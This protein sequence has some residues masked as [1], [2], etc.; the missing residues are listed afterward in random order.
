M[1]IF[2]ANSVD[3]PDLPKPL[4]GEITALTITAPD[5]E[6]SLAFYQKLGFK[7]L[8]RAD[9]PFPW[10]QITDGALL[11]MLRQDAQ[12]Y[13]ALTYYVEDMDKIVAELEAK[14]INFIQRPKDS[15]M[16]KRYLFQSPDALNISLVTKV[17]GFVQPT[18]H[19]LLTMPQ[20]DLF[21]PDKYVNKACGIF[22]EFTHT[23]TDLDASL[24]FWEKIGFTY[25]SKFSAPYPWA[26]ASDGLAI[27][28]LHQTSSFD[29]PAITFFAADM[30]EKIE[31]LKA[32]G[33][34]NTERGG[35]SNVMI[36]TPEQQHLFLFKIGM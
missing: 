25:I 20:G 35:P 6:Q 26:I 28:G 14:G 5:L 4:L 16:I 1:Q 23:V 17:D 7:E 27:I 24:D 22:G 30:K 29:Y 2:A 11:I 15:D 9:W 34:P 12:L 32:E 21:S 3:M 19:T 13:I 18:G 8:Y 31:K 33:M 36:E 10:I